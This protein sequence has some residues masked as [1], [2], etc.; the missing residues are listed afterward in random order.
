[1]LSNIAELELENPHLL[2][3]LGHCLEQA[4]LPEEA[5]MVFEEVL[6]L[7]PEEP[8]LYR[9]RR[10]SSTAS[11]NTAEQSTCCTRW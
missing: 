6:R 1:M 2:R 8:Q 4:N 7:R 5:R 11:G 9:D 3:V 10:W